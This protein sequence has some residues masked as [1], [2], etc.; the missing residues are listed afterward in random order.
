[1]YGKYSHYPLQSDL[2]PPKG[3]Y[4]YFNKNQLYCD[5]IESTINF[6]RNGEWDKREHRWVPIADI[7][8][9]DTRK[10]KSL[11]YAEEQIAQSKPLHCVC[12]NLAKPNESYK[13]TIHDGIHRINALKSRSFTHVLA[14]VQSIIVCTKPPLPP[15]APWPYRELKQMWLNNDATIILGGAWMLNVGNVFILDSLSQNQIKFIILRPGTDTDTK[16]PPDCE[17]EV[18]V[19]ADADYDHDRMIYVAGRIFK[20][21]LEFHGKMKHVSDSILEACRKYAAI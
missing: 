15:G 17:L 16:S 18:K 5:L 8:C 6:E 12:L 10:P 21:N 20:D 11:V 1:M 3:S 2:S 4:P 13:Y 7:Q 9:R 19:T 14:R